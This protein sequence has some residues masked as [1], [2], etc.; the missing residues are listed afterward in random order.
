M[1]Q[2]EEHTAIILYMLYAVLFWWYLGD[3]GVNELDGANN[4]SWVW[5]GFG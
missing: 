1:Y 4:I 2:D 3:L 5:V